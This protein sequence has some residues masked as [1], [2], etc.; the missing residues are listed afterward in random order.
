M[1]GL[2]KYVNSNKSIWF[3]FSFFFR[4]LQLVRSFF[5]YGKPRSSFFA[6]KPHGKLATQQGKAR[7]HDPLSRRLFYD[8]P[9]YVNWACT[10]LG[11]SSMNRHT[12]HCL[13]LM[14]SFNTNMQVFSFA[15]ICLREPATHRFSTGGWN[16][17][18]FRL[19]WGKYL[20]LWLRRASDHDGVSKF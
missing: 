10:S 1:R 2:G 19:S 14:Y 12:D 4:L 17:N 6:P 5:L 8:F 20:V 16:Y 18:H 11:N 15:F 13:I 9:E 3:F 7:Q